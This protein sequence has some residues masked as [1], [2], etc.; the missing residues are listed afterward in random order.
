MDHWPQRSNSKAQQP[1]CT[2]E[3]LQEEADAKFEGSL[4]RLLHDLKRILAQNR[5]NIY[6]PSRPHLEKDITNVQEMMAELPDDM[7]AASDFVRD[8]KADRDS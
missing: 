7:K 4:F 1:P 6:E 8:H 5:G 3:Q 2:K